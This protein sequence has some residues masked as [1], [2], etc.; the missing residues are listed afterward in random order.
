MPKEIFNEDIEVLG[1]VKIILPANAQGNF[2]TIDAITGLV[3]YR[4]PAEVAVEIGLDASSNIDGGS[5]NTIYLLEQIL[6]GGN[7]VL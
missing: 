7:A 5:A 1:T 3:T 4:T 2:L 6:D